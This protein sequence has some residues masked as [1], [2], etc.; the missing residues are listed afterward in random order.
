MTLFLVLSWTSSYI[1]VIIMSKLPLTENTRQGEGAVYRPRT[2]APRKKNHL[3]QSVFFI[4]LVAVAAYVIL[5]SP[6]FE[7]R[8]FVVTGN[9]QLPKEDLIKY[10]G[11]NYGANL[12]KVNLSDAEEKLSLVPLVKKATMERVLPDKI[13]INVVERKAV[14]LVPWEN[15]F[16]K[17]DSDGVYLQKGQIA[18][19]LPI[20]TGL[21]IK[22]N[23]PGKKIDSEHLPVALNALT[24]LPRTLVM[25]LS[26]ININEAGQ[27]YL[28]TID[29]VQG[30]MGLPTDL[31]YKANVFQQVISSIEQPGD[32]IEYVDLSNPKVPVVKYTRQQEGSQ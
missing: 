4:L 14:A 13:V 26:E 25:N 9:R 10:S 28:Y 22:A 1:S 7:I 20:I 24:Q 17:V 31:P 12:F 6:I 29:G 2:G 23:G 3:V 19:A 16:I 15:S 27:I 30:R 18:S 32:E 21:Q 8:E 5:Q 11:L